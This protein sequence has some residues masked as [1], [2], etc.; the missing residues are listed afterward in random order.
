MSY[1]N[2]N[3]KL[4]VL[5]KKTNNFLQYHIVYYPELTEVSLVHNRFVEKPSFRLDEPC[6]L[7]VYNYKTKKN[8]DAET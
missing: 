6:N 5:C 1:A 8:K 3:T 2:S 4:S 7:V